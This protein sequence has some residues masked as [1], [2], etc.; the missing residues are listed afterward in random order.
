[1]EKFIRT[2][3]SIWEFSWSQDRYSCHLKKNES[4]VLI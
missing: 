4:E 1:M 2:H 3:Y